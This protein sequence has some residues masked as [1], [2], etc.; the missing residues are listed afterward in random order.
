MG[1]KIDIVIVNPHN[2]GEVIEAFGGKRDSRADKENDELPP[3]FVLP[4]FELKN[5]DS[6]SRS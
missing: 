5:D 2:N 6:Q 1:G 3:V 4:L